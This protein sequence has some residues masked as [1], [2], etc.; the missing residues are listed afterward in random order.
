[1]KTYL[2]NPKQ[3]WFDIALLTTGS[4][5]TAYDLAQKN[6][7]QVTDPFTANQ[8]KHGIELLDEV[9]NKSLLRYLNTQDVAATEEVI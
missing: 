2:V 1:M 9:S 4:A 7:S 3:T 6:N 5:E 8:L